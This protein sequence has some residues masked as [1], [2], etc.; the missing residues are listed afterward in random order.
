MCIR[1]RP[2]G[3]RQTAAPE[4]MD[5]SIAAALPSKRRVSSNAPPLMRVL[6]GVYVAGVHCGQQVARWPPRA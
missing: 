1:D 4:R 5:S 3:P 6:A 2:P